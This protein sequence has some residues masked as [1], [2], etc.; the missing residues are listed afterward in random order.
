MHSLF[1]FVKVAGIV[2]LLA[3]D[4]TVIVHSDDC[5]APAR[6]F[7]PFSVPLTS[8]TLVVSLSEF[9]YRKRVMES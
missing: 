5:Q 6:F 1:E 2:A 8:D 3:G 9:G 7:L 4:A